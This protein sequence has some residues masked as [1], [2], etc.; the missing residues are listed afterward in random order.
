VFY[1]TGLSYLI[2]LNVI[3]YADAPI[4]SC[5]PALAA[6]GERNVH[7]DCSVRARPPLTALFWVVD[8]NGTTVADGEVVSEYWTRTVAVGTRMARSLRVIL[9]C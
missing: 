5:Q 9:S 6:P 7:L 1:F 2:T 3:T 8:A 4:V